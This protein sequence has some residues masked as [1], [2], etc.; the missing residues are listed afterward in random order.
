MLR[1]RLRASRSGGPLAVASPCRTA[2][3][4]RIEAVPHGWPTTDN[5]R[6]SLCAKE[7]LRHNSRLTAPDC[8]QARIRALGDAGLWQDDESMVAPTSTVVASRH[9]DVVVVGAGPNGLA[10]AI[11]LGRAGLNVTVMEAQDTIGGGCRTE[12][13]TLPGY[14]HD[15]CAAI[16][17]MGVASPLFQRLRLTDYGVTWL[18]ARFGLA[19]PLDDGRVALLSRRMSDTS[20]SLGN[21]GE[22]WLRL[23]SPFVERQADFFSDVL[24]P[25]RWPRHTG[26]MAR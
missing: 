14:R 7:R 19:H 8:R 22:E 17:P 25:I 11:V 1:T 10:A 3:A 24:R 20:A 2:S 5:R 4:T 12:T 18:P 16:H 9:A 6:K 13:L 23:M 26:L 15:V 21:D